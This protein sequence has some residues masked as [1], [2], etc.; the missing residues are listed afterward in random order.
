MSMSSIGTIIGIVI[1]C[2]GGI[3]LLAGGIVLLVSY[4]GNMPEKRLGENR[5]EVK[6]KIIDVT[7]D[8]AK[9]NDKMYVKYGIPEADRPKV[10]LGGTETRDPDMKV[11]GY[12]FIYAYTVDDVEYTKADEMGYGVLHPEEKL[13]EV[14]TVMY[15]ADKPFNAVMTEFSGTKIY[16]SLG[17]IGKALLIA[18]AVLLVLGAGAAG[19][20]LLI[21]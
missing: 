1:L 7:N 2:L 15:D 18:G 16:K 10:R 14:V 13:G 20:S 11:R 12:H 4:I 9:Y 17:P 8:A 5:M 19:L 6:G 21:F 3:S